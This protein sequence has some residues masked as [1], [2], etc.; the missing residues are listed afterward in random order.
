MFI[1]REGGGGGLDMR[2]EGEE[3]KMIFV[4][5]YYGDIL[6]KLRQIWNYRYA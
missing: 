1:S 6:L 4:W 5:Y 2:W 3:E